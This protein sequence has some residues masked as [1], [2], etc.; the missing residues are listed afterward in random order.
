MFHFVYFERRWKLSQLVIQ[1]K[2]TILKYRTKFKFSLWT[3]NFLFV[4]CWIF[5]LQI[6]IKF[7]KI[8]LIVE[9][10]I[11]AYSD[12]HASKKI[13]AKT[14]CFEN[15]EIDFF[16][17]ATFEK[18]SLFCFF[19]KIWEHQK[20]KAISTFSTNLLNNFFS[21]QITFKSQLPCFWIF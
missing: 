15:L 9:I 10:E 18:T 5:V 3:T 14:I 1:K 13:F 7:C 11:K 12:L 21:M 19:S 2:K 4:C 6:F 8:E 16:I 20:T 17:R